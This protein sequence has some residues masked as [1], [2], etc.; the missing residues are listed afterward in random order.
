MLHCYKNFS[1]GVEACT[2]HTFLKPGIM[3]SV[4]LL[5]TALPCSSPIAQFPCIGNSIH[6]IY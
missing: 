4:S 5:M 6:A 2:L 1:C 3:V